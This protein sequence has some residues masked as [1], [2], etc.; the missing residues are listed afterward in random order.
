MD[1]NEEDAKSQSE[2]LPSEALGIPDIPVDAYYDAERKE[3]LY[4][5][6]RGVWRSF[7]EGQF[8]KRLKSLGFS[9]GIPKDESGKPLQPLSDADEALLWL[10][11]HRDIDYHGKLCGRSV[12]FYEEN[13]LRFLVTD[14]PVFIEPIPGAW[15][16]LEA[17][18]HGLLCSGETSHRRTQWHTFLGWLQTSVVAL[19]SGEIQQAQALALAGPTNC[20]KSLLQFLITHFLGGRAAKAAHFMNGR[21]DFNGEL[22]EAEHLMLEDEFMSTR[23][24]DRLKLGAAIKNLTVSTQTA[25][26][27]R[28]H[29]H[30][31]N[32][33]GWWRVTITLNDDPEALLVLPPLDD[34]IED[35]IIL[36]R[37]SRFDLPMPTG[38]SEERRKFQ[39]TLLGEIPAFLH[40]L[41]HD[42]ELPKPYRDPKRYVV[43]TWHHPEMRR[44]VEQL[45]P[46]SE[47][48]AL[49]DRSILSVASEDSWRGTAEELREELISDSETR[50]EAERLL[51]NWP[52][53]CGTYLG[54][55][56]KK[57]PDR[58][59][60]VRTN[61]KREWIILRADSDD[62]S[63]ETVEIPKPPV[64]PSP[65]FAV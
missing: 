22:F 45:S 21:T 54:R 51:G 52:H 57:Q 13:G 18:L 27:H 42:Y 58:V 9:T 6:E 3:Y 15:P 61:R 46:E 32:L 63:E 28:K 39:D 65:A 24:S 5:N 35:K 10:Q 12:G 30:P 44:A 34:H 37:A 64:T 2:K 62:E 1:N 17:V 36:L 31:V 20:G 19:R 55:L 23:I 14:S 25:S 41:L 49:I 47:L 38:T 7:S 16:I 43:E 8:K 60:R 40:F 56:A 29:R 48:L 59:Q 53:A 4:Q 50:R 26:C 11:D 33:P